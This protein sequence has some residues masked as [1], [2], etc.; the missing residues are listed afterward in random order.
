MIDLMQTPATSSKVM[1]K[2]FLSV[3]GTTESEQHVFAFTS[4]TAARAEADAIKDALS[5]TITA[6]KATD[7]SSSALAKKT[8]SA[9]MA[10]AGAVSAG[11]KA[12]EPKPAWFNDTALKSDANLQKSLLEVNSTLKKTFLEALR[13]K[14]ESM[15]PSQLTTQFWSTRVHLLRAHAIERSQQRGQYNVLSTI[16]IPT[17]DDERKISI[18]KEQI[19]LIFSIHPLVK[20]IYDESVPNR[21]TETEFWSIFFVSRIFKKL[22]GERITEEDATN[23]HLDK[24]LN[25][26]E[27]AERSNRHLAAHVP[28]IIDVEGNEVNHSQRKGNDGDLTMRPSSKVPILRS[29]NAVSEKLIS[30]M[31]P[32]DIDPSLPIGID[33]ETFNELA[34]RDLQGDLEE[35]QRILNIRDQ[36]RFFA[37]GKESEASADALKYAKQNPASVL[38]S[39]RATLDQVTGK[40]TLENSIGFDPDSDSDED[41][42]GTAKP[43][44]GSRSS[45]AAATAQVL[46]TISQLRDQSDN[47]TASALG[48]STG[49]AVASTYGLS[50]II[51]ERLSLTHATTM[52]F[53]QQF[54]N[55]FLSG[56]PGRADELAKLIETLGNAIN[57][58]EAV[59]DAAESERRANIEKLKKE[60]KDFQ[61]RT[62]KKR[63]L[64]SSAVKGGAKVVNQLFA[65]TLKSIQVATR[66]Y[67]DELKRQTAEMQ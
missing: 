48:C 10:T 52:E 54:W 16:Q 43:H 20:R 49:Q 55:A 11:S 14:P 37:S 17:G 27:D 63:V 12:S 6:I 62:G 13:T 8:A 29:I 45:I 1:L 28:H 59:A 58:I 67:S 53:M 4:K 3:P 32:H 22:K 60:A 66:L 44:V 7:A 31:A 34:L 65:S 39:L 35:H 46:A 19:H 36:S 33:E 15:S 50:S 24:Y 51:F 41:D 64:G 25:V 2:I 38:F 42:S 61:E 40:Q 56:D 9:A 23:P 26:D 47:L 57:R 18:S 5:K 21:F 30:H